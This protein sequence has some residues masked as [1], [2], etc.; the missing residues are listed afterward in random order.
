MAV[1]AASVIDERRALG[2]SPPMARLAILAASS[3]CGAARAAWAPTVKTAD[4]L[5]NGTE[6]LGLYGG[7]AAGRWGYAIPH[8]GQGPLSKVVR[9]DLE[10]L[11]S[12]QILDLANTQPYLRGFQGG[13]EA[14]GWG[15]AVP[16]YNAFD[17]GTFGT[18]VRFDLETFS[19]LQALDL[20]QHDAALR[21]FSAGFAAGAWGYV[22][23]TRPHRAQAPNGRVA[24][25]DLQ[26]FSVVESLDL[27]LI[28]PDLNSFG[29]AFVAGGWGYA[30][31]DVNL[32]VARFDLATLSQVQSLD[33]NLTD[34]ALPEY[35]DAFFDGVWGYGVPFKRGATPSGKVVRFSVETFSGVQILDLALT[36][37]GL[38]G[39]SRG[40]VAGPWGYLTQAGTCDVVRFDLETFSVVQ[41]L[42]LA[43]TDQGTSAWASGFS[44]GG[45][46]YVLSRTRGIVARV[47]LT[48]TTTTAT[49]TTATATTTTATV[50]AS[51]AAT[52]ATATITTSLAATSTGMSSLAASPST[53]R[54]LPWHLRR[55]R[56]QLVVARRSPHP[57]PR[58]ILW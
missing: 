7:F 16:R 18:V 58:S 35:V 49:S 12:T 31:P 53:P 52:T 50:T 36:N 13:F 4:L 26:T 2:V 15:Y 24:R 11:G 55:R 42:Q 28:D 23:S 41:T 20:D 21:C 10:T 46:A 32:K 1:E 54:R 38:T 22:V 3:L 37:T 8:G 57:L 27:A 39:F 43:L 9:F 56:R 40:F 17:G 19:T 33:L 25:F 29:G 14:S 47:D 51:L 44:S 48:T 5:D 34:P 6:V 45:S 30:V